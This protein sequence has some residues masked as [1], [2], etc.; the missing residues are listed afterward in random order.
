MKVPYLNLSKD[1]LS[2]RPDLQRAFL[3]V[4]ESGFVVNGKE[5]KEFEKGYAKFSSTK[6]SVG[7]GNGL[8][9]LTI[10]LRILNIGRGDEVIV[11]S[12]TYIATLIAVS[13]TGATPV[14]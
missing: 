8:D 1:Y 7:V 4:L 2:I 13:R 5:L 9:A 11:P 12:N 6:Y 3:R 10:S 14:L